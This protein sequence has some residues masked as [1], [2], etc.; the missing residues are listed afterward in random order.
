[1]H[2]VGCKSVGGVGKKFEIELSSSKLSHTSYPRTSC[3]FCWWWWLWCYLFIT[4]LLWSSKMLLFQL[5]EFFIILEQFYEEFFFFFFVF[6]W[7]D[8]DLWLLV[9]FELQCR[10]YIYTGHFRFSLSREIQRLH[11]AFGWLSGL[12]SLEILKVKGMKTTHI[13]GELMETTHRLSF[14]RFLQTRIGKR[15]IWNN[16][17]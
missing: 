10:Y 17:V 12:F 11:D 15:G 2:L 13:C 9:G 5:S 7:L 16:P 3:C 6:L 4:I 14:Q 1:M 8:W